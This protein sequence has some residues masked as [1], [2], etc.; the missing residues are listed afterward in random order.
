[1][2]DYQKTKI[3]YIEVNGE[4][5]Y[6]HT[7]KNWLCQRKAEHVRDFVRFSERKL[8]KTIRDAGLNMK[9]LDL[10]LVENYPCKNVDEARAREAF[11]IKQ[12][13][14]LNKNM[15]GNTHK[16][17]HEQNKEQMKEYYKEYRE[18]NKQKIK[19]HEKQYREQNKE[20]ITEKMKAWCSVRVTCEHCGLELRRDWIKR[21]TSL[22]HA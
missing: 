2:P 20:Q 3:Y 16:E 18:Q 17:W 4:K 8:Y 11:W 9:D 21:H 7:V 22:K 10:V 14:A 5:Y 19:E 12:E 15:P 13:G 1:M 6:G